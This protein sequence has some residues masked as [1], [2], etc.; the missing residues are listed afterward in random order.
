MYTVC[1]NYPFLFV[2]IVL[3]GVDVRKFVTRILFRYK[4]FSPADHRKTSCSSHFAAY[5]TVASH[6]NGAHLKYLA[7]RYLMVIPDPSL[8]TATTYNDH[9]RVGRLSR[10]LQQRS[11][12]RCLSIFVSTHE[13]HA[14]SLAKHLFFMALGEAYHHPTLCA[15]TV[16][17]YYPESG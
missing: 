17:T 14:R 11:N 4:N 16:Q 2:E 12:R 9:A 13:S 8:I 5:Y 15:F 7:C 6:E 1:R 10:A 3:T